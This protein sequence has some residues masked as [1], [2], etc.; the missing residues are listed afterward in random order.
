MNQAK[1]DQY[2]K[3][4][5]N[6]V[7][8]LLKENN[9]EINNELQEDDNGK[10]FLIALSCHVPTFMTRMIVEGQEDILLLDHNRLALDLIIEDMLEK[11]SDT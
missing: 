8:E 6:K 11:V 1:I 9:E 5:Y 10:C 3:A 4:I 2:T 7:L